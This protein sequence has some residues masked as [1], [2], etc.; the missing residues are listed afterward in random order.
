MQRGK[1]KVV[2]MKMGDIIRVY[3]V[4]RHHIPGGIGRGGTEN[5]GAS[6]HETSHRK[7][8]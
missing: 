1:N 6:T 5:S 7:E 3:K 4:M 8:W 2:V